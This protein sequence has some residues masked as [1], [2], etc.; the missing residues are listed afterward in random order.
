MKALLIAALFAALTPN[1]ID[2]Q[3]INVVS[4]NMNNS[5]ENIEAVVEMI[6]K[7]TPLVAGIQECPAE[8]RSLK[9]KLPGYDCVCKGTGCIFYLK[10]AVSCGKVTK[11]GDKTIKASF[12]ILDSKRCFDLFCTVIGKNDGTAPAEKILSETKEGVPT[13]VIGTINASP[14]GTFGKSRTNPN[15]V[16]RDKFVDACYASISTDSTPSYH[17]QGQGKGSMM[18]FIYYSP[19]LSGMH[20]RVLKDEYAGVKYMSDHYAVRDIIRFKK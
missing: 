19:E 18:D 6:L 10:D 12:T 11:V 8:G 3:D 14:A 1:R 17:K 9:A 5:E 20:F 2:T 13:I 15:V 4:F 7:E 16:L